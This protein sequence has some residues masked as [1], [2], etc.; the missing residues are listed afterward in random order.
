MHSTAP[1][2]DFRRAAEAVHI[3]VQE[4]TPVEGVK[5]VWRL[6]GELWE[7]KPEFYALMELYNS[8]EVREAAGAWE[9]S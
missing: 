9:T 1:T 3:H 7:N 8:P 4:M 2:D 6:P 5:G